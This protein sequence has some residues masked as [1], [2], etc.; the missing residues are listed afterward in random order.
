[1]DTLATPTTIEIINIY[2]KITEAPQAK[3]KAIITVIMVIMNSIT[4]IKLSQLQEMHTKATKIARISIKTII[5]T[6][7]AKPNL[8][9]IT[10]TKIARPNLKV[11]ITTI[12][13]IT[14]NN[15]QK[16]M[17]M[18]KSKYLIVAKNRNMFISKV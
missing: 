3:L 2:I 4:T 18:I 9:A 13:I 16:R 5:T 6:K 1:M 17:Q 11:I 10:T 14:G 7:I 15:I 8:K 12:T